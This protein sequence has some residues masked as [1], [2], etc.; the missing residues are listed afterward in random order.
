[1][2][3]KIVDISSLEPRELE[4]LWEREASLWLDRLYWDIS[5]VLAVI[6]RAV[7]R[8]SLA[9]KAAR[10][11]TDVVGYTYYMLEGH[12][13]VL[14][15][16]V[17]IP[18]AE[19]SEI[20]SRVLGSL[21]ASIDTDPSVHRIESQFISFGLP[22]LS[23]FFRAHGFTEYNRRFLRRS[24]EATASEIPGNAGFHFELCSPACLN[25]ASHLM[26][27]AHEGSI[28]AEDE[29]AVSNARGLPN[30]IGQHPSSAG[31]R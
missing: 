16:L 9:G 28:D 10:L 31:V 27:E 19:A 24:L 11:G 20:G 22:W 30:T 7:E 4:L 29:R 21:L 6:R 26:Q 17:F 3:I 18:K 14:G 12:R 15:S 13:A 5:P 1:M 25:E 8:K 23:E 2:P